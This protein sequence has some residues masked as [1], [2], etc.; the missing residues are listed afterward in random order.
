MIC[1]KKSGGYRASNKNISRSSYRKGHQLYILLSLQS[2]SKLECRWTWPEVA[3]L[4]AD[5]K[6][7]GLWGRECFSL[8][9]APN[10]AR[11]PLIRMRA[12]S[13]RNCMTSQTCKRR[14]HALTSLVFPSVKFCESLYASLYRCLLHN[15]I[16]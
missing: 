5:Q 14:K 16:F 11:G 2:H 4:G 9:N 10:Y 13:S 12:W 8:S 3:I 6:E 15:V 7:R 1:R